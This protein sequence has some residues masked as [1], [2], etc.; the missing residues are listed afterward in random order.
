MPVNPIDA[1][2]PNAPAAQPRQQGI[3]GKDDFLKLLIG[4]LQHQ[5]PLSPSDPSEQMG[6]MTQFSILEQ[7][8]NLAQ[9]QQAAAANDYD[10]Q[11]VALIGRTV[12]YTSSDGSTATGVV[13]QVTFTSRGPTLTIGGEPGIAPVVVTEV[14]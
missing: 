14:R 12:T 11:A 13:E 4:Q 8:S 5:D 2:S 9:S 10:Q 6:Q 3:L 7:L 1:A